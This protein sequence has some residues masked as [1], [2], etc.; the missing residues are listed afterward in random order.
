MLVLSRKEGERIVIG[1]NVELVVVAITSNRVRL[2]IQA[3][4]AVVVRR[5][6]LAAIPRRKVTETTDAADSVPAVGSE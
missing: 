4:D 6:E 1:D 5:K 2:G 3:P